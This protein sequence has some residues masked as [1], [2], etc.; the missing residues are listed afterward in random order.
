MKKLLLVGPKG[1]GKLTIANFLEDNR[2]LPLKKVA[3]IVYHQKTIIVPDSYLE[4]P[5]MH[6]HIIAL[7]QSATCALFLQPITA[8]RRSYPPNFSKVFRIP[9]YGVVTYYQAYKTD[10][11][12]QAQNQLKD[13]GIKKIDLIL[14]LSSDDEKKK[15]KQLF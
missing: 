11:L 3:S 14:D 6:K 5:W 2:D 15:I 1:S 12:L 8:T 13:C 7:Q 9:I 10:A 4:S